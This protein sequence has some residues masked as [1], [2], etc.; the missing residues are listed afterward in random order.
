MRF[1][2]RW[3]TNGPS[4]TLGPM[5]DESGARAAVLAKFPAAHFSTWQPALHS[6][7]AMHL[8]GIDDQM[9]VWADVNAHKGH[10]TPVADLL[11]AR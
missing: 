5:P 10:A 11:R 7:S 3:W 6:A 2:L 1:Y 9:V 4:Q 8:T